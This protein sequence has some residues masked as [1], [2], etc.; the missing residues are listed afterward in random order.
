MTSNVI[1]SL[2]ED[3][4]ELN[5]KIELLE[6]SLGEF[7]TRAAEANWTLLGTNSNTWT[8][9][10]VTANY[11]TLTD[12]VHSNPLLSRGVSLRHAYVYGDGVKIGNAVRAQS[13]VSDPANRDAFFSSQAALTRLNE[14]ASAGN[15]FYLVNPT[16][17]EVVH[18]PMDQISG[19]ITDD[20]DSSKIL[21][22]RRDWN[23]NGGSKSEWFR[24][25]T[26]SK[27]RSRPAEKLSGS[28]RFN[29]EWVM[30]HRGY[31]RIAGVALG[32]PDAIAVMKWAEAYTEYL[33]NQSRLVRAYSR[34]AGRV[35]KER[36]TRTN[37][38]V[39][40]Q[41]ASAKENGTYGHTVTGDFQHLPATGSQVSFD[42]GRPMAALVAAG[43][44]VGVD[45]LLSGTVGATKSVSDMLDLAT[46]AIMRS[47]QRDEKELYEIILGLLGA[48][49]A[50]VD[51]PT[52]DHDPLYRRVAS[53]S[54]ATA[55][56]FVFRREARDILLDWF[57]ITNPEE[58]LPEP[59]GFN[60]WSDP[61]SGD[62]VDP[63]PRQGHSGA[64]G[65]QVGTNHDARDNGEYDT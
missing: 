8:L 14:R 49:N 36:N 25:H 53:L 59:D 2:I 57:N 21:F 48:P 34:I 55:Q 9:S 42:N 15:L 52:F 7:A 29:S 33:T 38:E 4:A 56:G 58:G 62:P 22:V 46:G 20:M 39:A 51:F 43:L 47:L 35:V 5:N 63:I 54:Q 32:V 65:Q 40:T 17:R 18:V 50:E 16:T 6:E 24:G 26:N 3:N 30:V 23:A 37:S 13:A 64:V 1:Q 19:L 41:L 27:R 45:A 31:N 60:T 10:N 28:A 44:G 12:L 61:D 11:L